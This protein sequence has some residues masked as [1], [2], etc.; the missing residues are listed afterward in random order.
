MMLM[1]LGQFVFQP[2]ALSFNELQRQRAWN[3]ADNA[4]A[5]GRSKKQFIGAGEDN[6]TL[7]GIVVQ[8][9]GVGTRDGIEQLADMADSGQG[10]VLMDGSGYL[11]GVYIITGIDETKQLMIFNGIPRKIDFSIKLTRVDDNRIER[12]QVPVLN[13]AAAAVN[14]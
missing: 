9:H 11:Y 1:V 12:Q 10:Y 5:S 7:S 6:V 8:E 3:F 4:V 13:T 2:D 14:N